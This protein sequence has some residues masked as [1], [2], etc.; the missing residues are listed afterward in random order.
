MAKHV[1]LDA[2]IPREDFETADISL[3]VGTFKGTLSYSDLKRAEFF[4]AALRKPDFQRETS[5]W[6]PSKVADF[7]ESFLIGDL[8]PAAILWQS[9]SNLYF[10]IDGAHRLSSLAAWINDD[11]GDGAISQQFYETV[12]PDE[13]KEIGD[14]TR[15]LV[16]KRVGSFA[17]YMFAKDNPPKAK[18]ELVSRALAL[19]GRAIQLQWVQGDSTKAEISFRNINQKA[20][21]INATEMRVLQFRRTPIG[22]AARAIIRSGRGHKYWS[23][24]SPENMAKLEQLSRDV[25]ALLF[26]PRLPSPIKTLDL[27]VGGAAYSAQSL[28]LVLEFIE[29]VNGEGAAELHESDADGERTIKCITRC[30]K[31][32]ERI[33][34][35][36]PESLGLHPIV[37]FYS[38]NGRHKVAS[39]LAVAALVLDFEHRHQFVKFTGIREKFE[40]LLVQYDYLVQQIVRQRRGATAS[41]P[42]IKEFYVECVN[43][44]H[45]GRTVKETIEQIVKKGKFSLTMAPSAESD[46]K[47]D[48]SKSTKAKVFIRQSQESALRCSV[49]GGLLH[50]NAISVDHITRKGDGGDASAANAQLTHP[51]CNTGYKEQM[52]HLEKNGAKV[53]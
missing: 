24:F 7:I 30:K 4:Y 8:I 18:A 29:L 35:D 52:R 14:R 22:I 36:E 38:A 40:D 15:T 28:P 39:F 32:L 13:Q 9:D 53:R 25:N 37:Y 45:G 12:I 43:L 20:S 5:E 6:D 48:F 51:Y 50:V 23:K 21:P 34:S 10:V 11:Y 49:C 31:V 16:K 19:G 26:K 33:N 46:A 47:G 42:Q 17:D 27:P 41:V 44:L 1:N 3:Q 2:L